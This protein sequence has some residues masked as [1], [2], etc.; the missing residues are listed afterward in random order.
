M[1]WKR[2]KEEAL[3]VNMSL[4]TF[5]NSFKPQSVFSRARSTR[6]PQKVRLGTG[7]VYTII[8]FSFLKI[9]AKSYLSSLIQTRIYSK[10]LWRSTSEW[11]RSKWV[12]CWSILASKQHWGFF[13]SL[14]KAIWEDVW[15]LRSNSFSKSVCFVFIRRC[16]WLS[17]WATE[18]SRSSAS[19]P[20]FVARKE[21]VS[22]CM[23]LKDSI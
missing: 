14:N 21:T 19:S 7:K 1:L 20:S 11:Q 15:S 13:Q 6:R 2:A 10:L 17:V 9:Q 18:I 22:R 3:W 16:R 8:C 4:V 23:Q 5:L 12:S